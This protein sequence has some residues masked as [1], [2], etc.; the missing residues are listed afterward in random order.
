MNESC[1]TYK[2]VTSHTH[3]HTHILKSANG[4]TPEKDGGE[5]RAGIGERHTGIGERYTGI[6]E[7]KTEIGE[8]LMSIL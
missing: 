8:N 5:R 1:H 4:F 3:T 6:G 7:R 2:G